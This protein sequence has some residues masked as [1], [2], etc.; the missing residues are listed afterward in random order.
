MGES[1]IT[2]QYRDA[3]IQRAIKSAL[4][5]DPRLPIIALGAFLTP[6][7]LRALKRTAS[8]GWRRTGVP[9][10][11]LYAVRSP[12]TAL[13]REIR[14]YV[15]ALTRSTTVQEPDRRFGHRDFTLLHD[16]EQPKP[17]WRAFLFLDDLPAEC[18]GQLVFSADGETLG[19]FTPR[20]NTLLL[21]RQRR[22]VHSFVQYVNHRAG[23]R[24][25]RILSC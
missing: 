18:G 24:T 17:G 21:V 3:A 10:R 14:A 5:Q 6:S 9:D 11:G 12:R 23:K 19:T 16:H 7:A 25:V 15:R 8:E 4:R 22:G 1:P 2:A 13:Q 20:E